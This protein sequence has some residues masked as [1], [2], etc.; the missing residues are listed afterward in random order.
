MNIKT[1][2]LCFSNAYKICQLLIT[3]GAEARFIGGCVRDILVGIKPKDIDIATNFKP[4]MVE[5][6]LSDNHI[7]FYSTGKEFGTIIAI[8]DKQQIEI[9]TLRKDLECDGRY[10]KVQFTNNWQDD[11][12]RRDF[13]INAL[14]ADI[15]GQIYDYFGGISDLNNKVVKFIGEP[16][17]RI[18]EDYLRILRFFRFSAYFSDSIDHKGLE[19]VKKYLEGLKNISGYR[20]RVELE[21]IFYSPRVI[22]ILTIMEKENILKNISSCDK[23]TIKTISKLFEIFTE[24]NEEIDVLLCWA[25]FFNQQNFKNIPFSR[26][27]KNMID[28]LI[29]ARIVNYDYSNLKEYWQKYKHDFKKILLFNMSLSNESLCKKDIK[30]F[31]NKKIEPL[32]VAGKDLLAINIHPGKKIGLLLEVA[33]QIWYKNDFK[34]TKQELLKELLAYESKF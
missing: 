25:V 13:T 24:F 15:N 14:S 20:V 33:E 1:Q 7:N 30:M 6:I 29:N 31:F 12:G 9:T 4:E 23:F 22:E 17:Q 18:Q 3:A 5:K 34:I 11:A 21:K 26:S 27:E 2:L 16:E 19:Q 8:I 10:A 28:K 32:P